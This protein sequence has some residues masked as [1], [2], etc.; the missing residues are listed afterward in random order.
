MSPWQN[1]PEPPCC[2]WALGHTSQHGRGWRRSK[3]HRPTPKEQ[4]AEKGS[5]GFSGPKSQF[6]HAKQCGSPQTSMSASVRNGN[7]GTCLMGAVAVEPSLTQ[8]PA[9]EFQGMWV[10]TLRTPRKLPLKTIKHQQENNRN[11]EEIWRHSWGL[12]GGEKVEE[13]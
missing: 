8:W 12:Q 5:E 1:L 9:C 3:S 7:C 2:C 4:L 13:E 11:E 10:F 6:C